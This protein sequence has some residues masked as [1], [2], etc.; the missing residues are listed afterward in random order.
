[1]GRLRSQQRQREVELMRFCF[2]KLGA[3]GLEG[4][5]VDLLSAGEGVTGL[6]VN[7]DSLISF[8]AHPHPHPNPHPHPLMLM[9]SPPR[10]PHHRRDRGARVP[11][12]GR[13]HRDGAG[14][15]A[16]RH[17]AEEVG[18]KLP[19]SWLGCSW[20]A[21]CASAVFWATAGWDG[22]VGTIP[23]A[24]LTTSTIKHQHTHH[25]RTT[26]ARSCSNLEACQQL[27][28]R[29]LLGTRRLG[30]VRDDFDRHQVG[31]GRRDGTGAHVQ[32]VCC[33]LCDV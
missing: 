3:W 18:G 6:A 22:S 23:N 21:C 24:H 8:H 14:P 13:F 9:P 25:T 11:G 12:G 16:G 1:M 26:H 4:F 5:D 10:P 7:P 32:C 29:D 19:G 27:M 17:R 30:V 15:G 31:A 20:H 33:F 2:N 28:D